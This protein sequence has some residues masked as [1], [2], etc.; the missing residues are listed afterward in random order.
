MAERQ[1]DETE[2]RHADLLDRFWQALEADAA[3]AAPAELPGELTTLS[4]RLSAGARSAGPAPEFVARLRERLAA[5]SPATLAHGHPR[6]DARPIAVHFLGAGDA[7]GSGGRLQACILL[8]GSEHPTL[9]DCGATSLVAMKRA[10]IAPADIGHV[11]ISHLHGDHFGGLPYLILDGQFARRERPLV[12]AGPAG[13]AERVA[14][15]MEASFPGSTAVQRAFAVDFVELEDQRPLQIGSAWVTPFAVDHA[16]GAPAFALRVEYGE[17]TI[18]YSGDTAWTPSLLE[19]SRG[20]DLFIC[21]A[22]FFEKQVRFHL[23]YRTA[24]AQL[25]GHPVSR[26]VLTHPSADLLSRRSELEWELADDG[27]VIAL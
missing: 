10:T 14:A 24:Q 4:R 23:D 9:L 1:T 16:S 3:G 8:T 13:I 17:R 18:A 25:A 26:I 21:E 22:Y 20:A 27:T 6:E 2:R 15:L 5:Q 11:L 12:I 7:M 19:V